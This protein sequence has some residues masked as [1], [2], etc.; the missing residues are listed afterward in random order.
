[1]VVSH[2]RAVTAVLRRVAHLPF[3]HRILAPRVQAVLCRLRQALHLLVEVD[4]FES[5][6]V[7]LL[8]VALVVV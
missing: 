5:L 2:L 6:L 7:R 1:M 3:A 4:R 8:E